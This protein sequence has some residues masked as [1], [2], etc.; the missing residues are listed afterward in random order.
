MTTTHTQTTTRRSSSWPLT[1][2]TPSTPSTAPSLTPST[3]LTSVGL[4]HS[5]FALILTSDPASGAADDWYKGVLGSRFTFTT[6]LRDTGNYGFILPA[7]QIKPS[8]EEMWAGFEV[9]IKKLLSL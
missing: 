1:P 5:N 9:E 7:S 3:L 8:G 2:A 6:E 4:N